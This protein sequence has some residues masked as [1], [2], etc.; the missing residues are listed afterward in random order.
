M[1][2]GKTMEF[3]KIIEKFGIYF[4]EIGLSKTYGRL[5]GHFITIQQPVSMG[6]LVEKLQISKSTASTEIRRLLAM[7]VIERVLLP[8]ER[9]DFYQLKKNIWAVNLGQKIQDIKKLR[10]IVEEVPLQKLKKLDSLK[11]LG[12]YC[13]FM[14]VELKQLVKKYAKFIEEKSQIKAL[15]SGSYI[16]KGK[17][18]QNLMIQWFKFNAL[19]EEFADKMTSLA[20]L[21]MESFRSVEMDF[22]L[23]YPHAMKEDPNLACFDG[24]KGTQLK[25]CM[26]AKLQHIFHMRPSDLND[27][28]RSLMMDAYYY[29]VTIKDEFSDKVQGF[30]TFLSGGPIPS[31]E[32]KITVLAVDKEARREGLAGCLINSLKKIGIKSKKLFVCTR[33]SNSG[34]INAYKK[35]GFVED[36]EAQKAHSHFINGH[37]IHLVRCEL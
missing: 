30:I 37:W 21:G 33:P 17:K 25:N 32:F 19:S 36:L 26:N 29:I 22:L 16:E 5:F 24:L 13:D 15:H 3:E 4:T 9:A 23:A 28:V 6:E 1:I 20:S 12:D 34:A 14:E 27:G 35:W 11:D 10:E 7:G 31:G 18:N 8:N 2:Q